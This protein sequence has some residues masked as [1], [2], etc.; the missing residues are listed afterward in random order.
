MEGC[1]ET[2]WE[3]RDLPFPWG[4]GSERHREELLEE[5]FT[6]EEFGGLT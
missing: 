6:F 3:T 2:E 4:F 5:V 1:E